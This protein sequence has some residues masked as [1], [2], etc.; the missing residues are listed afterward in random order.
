MSSMI[1]GGNSVKKYLKLNMDGRLSVA[2]HHLPS[3]KVR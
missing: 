3:D 1:N 2:V